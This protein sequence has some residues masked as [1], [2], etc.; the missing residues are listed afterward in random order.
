MTTV[1]ANQGASGSQCHLLG[2]KI[3]L[4]ALAGG[5]GVGWGIQEEVKI[6]YKYLGNIKHSVM[7]HC[8]GTFKRCCPGAF[9][10]RNI[11]YLDCPS[12]GDIA[13]EHLWEFI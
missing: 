10:R 7:R 12:Q 5:A 8:P 9:K 6:V 2:I 13:P 1:T 11:R 4:K 3:N